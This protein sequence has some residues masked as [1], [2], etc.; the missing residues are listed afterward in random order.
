[1]QREHLVD[2]EDTVVAYKN[3]KGKVKLDQTINL[4]AAGAASGGFWGLLIGLIFSLPF[5]G[6]MLPIITAVFGGGIGALSGALSDYGID[7]D[8][9]KELSADLDH[10]KAALFV[11]VRKATLDRVLEE[12]DKYE[13]KVLKTSLSHELEDKLQKVLDKAEEE[14]E[15]A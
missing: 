9:M 14:A 11:L 12:L 4:T 3:D 6:V 5:G 10:G 2:L 1:M 13:G 7:D 8:M 15:T